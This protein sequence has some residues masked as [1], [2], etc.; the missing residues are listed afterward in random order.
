MKFLK[1]IVVLLISVFC[2]A[3]IINPAWSKEVTVKVDCNQYG[4]IVSDLAKH[5]M[6][7]GKIETFKEWPNDNHPLSFYY[8]LWNATVKGIQQGYSP[9]QLMFLFLQ[10]CLEEPT[11][12]LYY[13]D[14][15][16]EG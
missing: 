15:A 6:T 13:D 12:E 7:G 14:G 4:Q 3:V 5:A 2:L 8:W 9:E 1:G 16:V 10:V 11:G